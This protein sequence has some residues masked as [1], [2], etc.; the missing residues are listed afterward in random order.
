MNT[1]VVIGVRVLKGSDRHLHDQIHSPRIS[2]AAFT[3]D[4]TAALDLESAGLM[5]TM[6]VGVRA[7]NINKRLPAMVKL[8]A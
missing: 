6:Y 8:N 7:F 4:A 1:E 5:S 3:I 2:L